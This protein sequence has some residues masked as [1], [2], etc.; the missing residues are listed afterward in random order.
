MYDKPTANIILNRK[1]TKA[2][3][4][5]LGTTEGCLLSPFLLK[6]VPEGLSRAISQ[7]KEIKDI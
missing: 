5:K 1:K 6:I 4:P 3:P 2:F 7:E